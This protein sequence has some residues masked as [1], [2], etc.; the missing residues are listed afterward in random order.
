MNFE[1]R[2]VPKIN[3]TKYSR[4]AQVKFVENTL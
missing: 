2:S 4:I 3:G 1:K